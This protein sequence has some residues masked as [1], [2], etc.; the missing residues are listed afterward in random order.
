MA[1]PPRGPTN[2]WGEFLT[3]RLVPALVICA[4][5]ASLTFAGGAYAQSFG[6]VVTGGTAPQGTAAPARPAPS[7]NIIQRVVVEG[8]QRIEAETVRAY[9]TLKAGDP[10]SPGAVND[11]LKSLFATGLFADVA[12]GRQGDA[13]VV[14]VVENPIINRIAFEGNRRVEDELLRAEV[15]LQ[16]RQVYTRTKVQEDVKRVLD[17]YRR[18]GRFAVTV[19]PKVI[20]LEQNRVDLVFEINEG[21][22][23]YVRKINFVGNQRY[24]D[25]ALQAE[26]ATRE[27]R[28]YRFFSTVD[29]YDPD[30][31]TYDRELLRR[32]YLRNGYSDFR[33]VSAV[34]EL[35]EDRTGFFITFTVDEGERY[36]FGE[37]DV[38]V[39]IPDLDE[40]TVRPAI[41]GETGDWYN[42]DEVE[43]TVQA[44]TDLAGAEGYAFV[45]VRPRVRRDRENRVIDITYEIQEGPR[46]FVDRI[47]INGN[48]RTLDSVIR[49]EMQLVEGDAFNTA[50]LRR[51]R[52]RIRNL[53]FFE[54]VEVTN[55][56][57]ETSPDRTVVQVDVEEQSTG[58]LSFGLG[59]SS[60]SGALF[61]VGVRERNLLG[62]GQ[63]VKLDLTLAQERTEIDLGFTEPYF[64]DR[65][66]RAGF[67][68]YARE[69]DL[70]DES[71]HDRGEKGGAV[72]MGFNYNTHL[73]QSLR[74]SLTETSIENVDADASRHIRQIEGDTLLSMVSQTLT[75]DRRDS[76][77]EPTE[78]YRISFG[79]DL[80]G[81]GGDET[82]V[83]ATLG[84]SQYTP[85]T[86]DVVLMVSGNV[87]WATGIGEDILLTRNFNLGGDN[88]RGFEYGGA[89]PRDKA[90]N[91]ILGG[92][93]IA[94]GTTE[95]RFPLGLPEELGLSGKAFTD[96]GAI[97]T[98]DGVPDDEMEESSMIR[99]SAGVGLVWKSPMGPLSVDLAQAIL[100]E[101]FDEEE[102]FRVNFGT[103]F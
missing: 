18:S 73:S 28:W 53:G 82:F 94:N 37:L 98:P 97:G 54:R 12:I 51:S 52:E 39:N 23:T 56:P 66:L 15:Q 17:V 4:V 95:L 36:K 69:L 21:P 80:A 96:F 31:L 10:Y 3:G 74:Y 59:W 6:T 86:D 8:N 67:D 72:R 38:Q 13:L 50:K 93:W 5:A 47:E 65:P 60:T 68:L 91:D 2:A 44:L 61:N 100:K 75:Y 20:Q 81:L 102:F 92:T 30:R 29:T 19:D 14:R 101:D 48:L 63:D 62:R 70:Q 41:V 34:A 49:R 27:E 58:E 25:A 35:T 77:I 88:L 79:T 32:F 26:I 22:P 90:T 78:G 40:D 83:R 103:R 71:S 55:V 87:G 76:R 7:S 85:V 57:S 24:S 9:M 99:L 1:E 16:P 33:V 43:E 84:A 45:E 11:S 89:S 42:A 64:M 46:V